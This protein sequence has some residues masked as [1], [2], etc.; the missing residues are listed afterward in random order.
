MRGSPRERV[1]LCPNKEMLECCAPR[2]EWEEEAERA[3]CSQGDGRRRLFRPSCRRRER[4]GGGTFLSPERR[5]EEA[6]PSQGRRNWGRLCFQGEERRMLYSQRERE[7]EL[8]FPERGEEEAF[9]EGGFVPRERE[10]F[11]SQRESKQDGSDLERRAI[12]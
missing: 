3:F 7:A 2:D 12:E 6:F 8:F 11:C 10:L 5:K 1:F 4:E 9:E